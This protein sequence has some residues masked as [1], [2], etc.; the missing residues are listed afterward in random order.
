MTYMRITTKLLN[1]NIINNLLV[2]RSKLNDLQEQL[3]TGKR[4]SKPSDDPNAAI[5]ILSAKLSTDQAER[6]ITNIENASSELDIT[7]QSILSTVD[8]VQRAK[9]LAVKASNATNG[10]T[11]LSAIKSEID[12]LIEQV[13]DAANTK[14]GSKYIFGGCVTEIP[15][16]SEATNGDITYNGTLST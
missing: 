16:Y 12:Q 14:F 4:V 1:D 2:N 11:E 9:E 5:N 15:P 13:K 7:D 8:V 6:Y 3:S 10:S